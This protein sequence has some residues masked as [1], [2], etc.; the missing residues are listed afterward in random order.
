MDAEK[1]SSCGEVIPDGQQSCFMCFIEPLEDDF[2]KMSPS[3]CFKCGKEKPWHT[4]TMHEPLM[5]AKYRK[6]SIQYGLQVPLCY[7]GCHDEVQEEPSQEYN[8]YLQVLMQQKFNR[9]QK[10]LNF[11]KIFGRSYL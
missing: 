5:G 7:P 8:K 4:I 3:V 6:L 10:E 11:M 2:P 1:C 9:E